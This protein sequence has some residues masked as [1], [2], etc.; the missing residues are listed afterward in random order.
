MVRPL[1]SRPR[2]CVPTDVRPVTVR[3]GLATGITI[4]SWV[5]L[6][7]SLVSWSKLGLCQR[8][9]IPQLA[10]LLGRFRPACLST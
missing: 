7:L 3:H 1:N 6:L 5:G 2:H 8:K 9:H 4:L 10:Q